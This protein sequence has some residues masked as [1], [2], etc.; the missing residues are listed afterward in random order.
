MRRTKLNSPSPKSTHNNQ[1]GPRQNGKCYPSNGRAEAVSTRTQ[2]HRQVGDPSRQRNTAAT[3]HQFY[4]PSALNPH[5]PRRYH[6]G[7]STFKR[8]LSPI[9]SA[10]RWL[11]GITRTTTGAPIPNL[12]LL[13]N[14]IQLN[15]RHHH[16][17]PSR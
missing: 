2:R 5:K 4:T 12:N 10:P 3:K 16:H 1:K 8:P 13:T 14:S 6:L 17:H 9:V 7:L 15:P 11:E